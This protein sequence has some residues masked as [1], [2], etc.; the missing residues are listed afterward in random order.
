[1]P[2]SSA[3]PLEVLASPLAGPRKIA[4]HLHFTLPYWASCKLKLRPHSSHLMIGIVVLSKRLVSALFSEF[5]A[6]LL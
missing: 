6:E 1:V 4:P 5:I 2:A 3:V